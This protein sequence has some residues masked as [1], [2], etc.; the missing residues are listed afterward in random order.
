MGAGVHRGLDDAALND[1]GGRTLSAP[2]I[3]AAQTGV[4]R[5]IGLGLAQVIR[6]SVHQGIVVHVVL[7]AHSAPHLVGRAATAV[8]GQLGVQAWQWAGGGS[9]AGEG[10]HGVVEARVVLRQQ[11]GGGRGHG[12]AGDGALAIATDVLFQ[13]VR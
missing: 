1:E 5:N 3:G 6:V 7:A 10:A 4:D 2:V 12:H 8:D 9:A 11:Q 13:F